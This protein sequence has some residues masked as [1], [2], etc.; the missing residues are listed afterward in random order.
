[1]L[2]PGVSSDAESIKTIRKSL[3]TCNRDKTLSIRSVTTATVASH[4]SLMLL[5]AEK[6]RRCVDIC[7]ELEDLALRLSLGGHEAL[8]NVHKKDVWKLSS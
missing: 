2:C 5:K 7:M 8:E 3:A 4:F 6:C 1:M